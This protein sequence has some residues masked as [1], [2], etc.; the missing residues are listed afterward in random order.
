MCA[1]ARARAH[2]RELWEGAGGGGEGEIH[3][4]QGL[5]VVSPHHT[6]TGGEGEGKAAIPG[7]SR[8]AEVCA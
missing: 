6:Q 2:H 1:R 4:G 8:E 3:G 5:C 7:K